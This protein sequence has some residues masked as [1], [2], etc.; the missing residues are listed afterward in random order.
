MQDNGTLT[1]GQRTAHSA[2]HTT[3]RQLSGLWGLVYNRDSTSNQLETRAVWFWFSRHGLM[4]FIL[5]SNTPCNRGWTLSIWS[6]S[7]LQECWD[8]I[9]Y[10]ETGTDVGF[11][12]CRASPQ[13]LNLPLLVLGSLTLQPRLTSNWWKSSCLVL[14][15]NLRLQVKFTKPNLQL[16]I[17][18]L[19]LGKWLP[20]GRNVFQRYTKSKN[21]CLLTSVPRFWD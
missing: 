3:R 7:L 1:A 10:M 21:K 19:I 6:L 13:Q 5:T 20:L 4:W 16:I 9:V 14:P 11:C 2:V 17:L 15:G 18:C 12:A 8:R